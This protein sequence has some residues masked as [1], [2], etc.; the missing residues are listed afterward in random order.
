LLERLLLAL[1]DANND[2]KLDL[3]ELP[4]EMRNKLQ[5]FD[6]DGD[7]KLNKQ[8]LADAQSELAPD[9]TAGKAAAA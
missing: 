5:K 2:G 4:Q 6:K 3:N 9:L 1:F 7:G 8:E